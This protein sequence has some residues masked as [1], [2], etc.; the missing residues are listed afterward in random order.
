M[1]RFVGSN[2]ELMLPFDLV[3]YFPCKDG[4]SLRRNSMTLF[5][6]GGMKIFICINMLFL[7]SSYTISLIGMEHKCVGGSCLY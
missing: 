4:C 2:V 3:C 7:L 5:D 6:F 1:S